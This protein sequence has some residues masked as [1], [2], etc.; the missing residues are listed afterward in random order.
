MSDP[1][2]P[3][4]ALTGLVIC[5]NEVGRIGACLASLEFCD[6]ILVI[7]SGSTDG[8]LAIASQAGARIVQ[9]PFLN[10][11]DQKDA[12]RALARGRWVLVID[13]DE[14]V[15]ADLQ[16]E[17]RS[18]ADRGGEPGIDAYRMPFRN[19]FRDTWVRRAGYYPDPHVRLLRRDRAH[20][21]PATPVH[22]KVRVQGGIGDL[23]GH[24][25]HHSF[26]SLDHFLAKSSRYAD[27]FA[28]A[29]YA[30]GRRA[31]AVDIFLHTLGRFVR[32]Y[33][34]KGGFLEGTLG[35]VI[36]GLQAYEVF[37][38]YARLWELGRWG[39]PGEGHLGP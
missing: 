5:H 19:H 21:D 8:T 31:G 36:S 14:V 24:V 26:V 23:R 6:E 18:I 22:E 15:S 9:R 33:V 30:E 10:F 27:R 39:A 3:E 11:A 7:D 4:V 29:A 17:V 25:D 13:A 32:A 20:F 38:K 37:Q 12:G 2:D 35:L 28:R 34:V 1:A 16:Q